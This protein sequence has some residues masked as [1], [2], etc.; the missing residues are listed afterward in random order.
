M[1]Y[2]FKKDLKDG[3]ISEKRLFEILQ[4]KCSQ[5]VKVEF[6]DDYRYDLKIILNDN[7]YKTFEIKRDLFTERTGNIAIETYCRGK[8][9]G[10]NITQADFFVIHC[11]TNKEH[12][13]CFDTNILKIEVER[14]KF[15]EISGGDR[16]KFGNP[17]TKFV[18]L[19]IEKEKSLCVDLLEIK[20]IVF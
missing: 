20:H 14:N 11:K 1:N 6:N 15:N 17:L 16:D 3:K 18:L 19:D 8:Q 4:E 12:F 13:Y 5:I 9:S 7:S 2:N 10:I